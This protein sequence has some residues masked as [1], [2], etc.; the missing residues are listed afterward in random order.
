[1]GAGRVCGCLEQVTFHRTT[2]T[3]PLLYLLFF[4]NG[5]R[6]HCAGDCFKI[7]SND[8]VLLSIF[9]RFFFQYISNSRKM[10]KIAS[11]FATSLKT[12]ICSAKIV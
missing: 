7:E 9:L 10:K 3:K 5:R 1:M 6:T 2:D 4:R 11:I 12:S 8:L